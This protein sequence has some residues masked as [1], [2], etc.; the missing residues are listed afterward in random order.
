MFVHQ[1]EGQPES[2][3]QPLA[4]M[5]VFVRCFGHYTSH[6]LEWSERANTSH[7]LVDL[8]TACAITKG[9]RARNRLMVN[10]VY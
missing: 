10:F 4:E 2:R 1:N 7:D 9:L 6:S 5:P 3:E 8:V